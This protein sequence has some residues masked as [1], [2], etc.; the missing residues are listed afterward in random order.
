MPATIDRSEKINRYFN[1][2]KL[3][4]IDIEEDSFIN[5]EGEISFDPSKIDSNCRQ[6]KSNYWNN[7]EKM[8]LVADISNANIARNV[9]CFL[10]GKKSGDNSSYKLWA[11]TDRELPLSKKLKLSCWFFRAKKMLLLDIWYIVIEY[12]GPMDF[13]NFLLCSEEFYV[14]VH[15]NKRYKKN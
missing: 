8:K 6:N 12:L 11:D 10:S 15:K 7:F 4:L 14:I 2:V 9:Q 1:S 3:L 5:S 13:C